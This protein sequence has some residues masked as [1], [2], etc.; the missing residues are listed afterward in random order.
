MYVPMRRFGVILGVL[1]ILGVWSSQAHAQRRPVT[2]PPNPGVVSSLNPFVNPA[3]ALHRFANVAVLGQGPPVGGVLPFNGGLGYGA[4][5][6]PGLG[7]G[8]LAASYA[9][10]LGSGSLLNGGYGGLGYGGMGYGGYGW[11][12]QWMQNPYEGYLTGAASVTRANAEYQQTIQQARLTRE[13]SRRSAIQTRRAWIEEAEWERAHMPDPEK[14]RVAQLQRELDRARVSPPLTEIWSG[15]SLNAL[16]RNAIAMQG[17]ARGQNVPLSEDTLKS[18]NLTVGDTRGNVGLLKDLKD[19]GNLRWPQPLKGDKFREA[20]EK[21]DTHMKRAARSVGGNDP[22]ESGI[23]NDLESDYDSLN[24]TLESSVSV[25]SPDQYTE[26]KRYLK[27]LGNTLVA[28]KDS[29]LANYFNGAW[30]A[31]GKSVAELVKHMSEQG[32]WF[33]PATTNDEAAYVALYHAMARYDRSLPRLASST[34]PGSNGA[35]E[36]K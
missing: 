34:S 5:G 29:N 11:G 15:K 3:A 16:L 2:V 26:A 22:V 1:S 9:A 32:L 36:E 35:S 4:L 19:N 17:Q 14:I 25:M 8:S 12:T 28:L 24:K 20:R 7:Y 6:A 33:A 21:M 31:K 18:I 27:V 13:E 10:G 30:T 23:I